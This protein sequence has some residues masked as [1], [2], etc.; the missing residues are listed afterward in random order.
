ME[1]S[2]WLA[3]FLSA[4]LTF[5]LRSAFLASKKPIKVPESLRDAM[6]FVPACALS[7][8]VFQEFFFAWHPGPSLISG[9]FAL[10]LALSFGK[11]LLT[12]GGGLALYWILT[13]LGFG[14]V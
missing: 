7:A 13:S 1:R 4:F 12:I 5:I 8:L 9:I 3:L 10:A 2:Y 6:G 11:D 14:Q